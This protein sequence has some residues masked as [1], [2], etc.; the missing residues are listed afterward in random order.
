MK[1]TN[2]L[3]SIV[4]PVFNEEEVILNT[5]NEI[6]SLIRGKFF[7][8]IIVINDGSSDETGK[9]VSNCNDITLINR[10]KNRGYGFSIKE[11]IKKAKGD[12]ILIIDADGSY[13]IEKI[14]VLI[15]EYILNH[16]M[17]V[18]ERSGEK[19][20]LSLFNRFAKLILKTL[21]YILTSKWIKDINSGLRIFDKRIVKKYSGIIPDGFSLTTT[22]TVASMIENVNVKFIPINYHKR[23]GKSKIS[24]IKDF[25]NFIILI[26]KIISFFKPLRF[27]FPIA[28]FFLV[29]AIT[30]AI[31][32]IFLFNSIETAAVLLFMISIQTF[33]FGLLAELIVNKHK[34][35]NDDIGVTS[36][37]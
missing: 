5:L 30:R 27:Y 6:H 9:I 31:R 35:F 14:P 28:A 1:S 17:V 16:G 23:V 15:D 25:L 4:I 18:G 13:P 8:E 2:E 10:D 3:I 19:V 32:D 21:I 36:D 34:T 37:S 33:F 7:Y 20:S 26:V 29:M 11:G 24:P 12:A 22:L